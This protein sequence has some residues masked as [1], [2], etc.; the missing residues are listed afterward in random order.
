MTVSIMGEGALRDE[1]KQPFFETI[2]REGPPNNTTRP[3]NNT[4]KYVGSARDLSAKKCN[5][6]T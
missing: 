1:P 3:P 2:N 6:E 5:C 4:A